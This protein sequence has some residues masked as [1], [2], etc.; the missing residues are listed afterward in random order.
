MTKPSV[1]EMDKLV[2]SR[3]KQIRQQ[4]K[5]SANTLA[6]FMDTSQQQ[7]SRYERGLNRLS[8]LLLWQLAGYFGVPLSWFF[9][10]MPDNQAPS[11][12]VDESRGTYDA[13]VSHDQLAILTR[14]W[15]TLG[16]LQREAILN[17][18]NTF[19]KLQ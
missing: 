16:P 4:H 1:S 10:D 11:L 7:V 13:T 17:M 14:M 18:L 3:L 9:L 19:L 5:I 8:G 6:E 15:P 2:G 12:L